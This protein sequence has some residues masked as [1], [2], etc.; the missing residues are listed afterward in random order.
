MKIWKIL[1]GYVN[2]TQNSR[3]PTGAFN[4]P[5]NIEK[6]NFIVVIQES[7]PD[8]DFSALAVEL[9][10][11]PER[12]GYDQKMEDLSPQARKLLNKIHSINRR[13]PILGLKIMTLLACDFG[14]TLYTDNF[15]ETI[16]PTLKTWLLS[17]ALP[18]QMRIEWGMFC[19]KNWPNLLANYSKNELIK[20][21]SQLLIEESRTNP[22]FILSIYD[23]IPERNWAG[24]GIFNEFHEDPEDILLFAR[25]VCHL[26][27]PILVHALI[28]LI[29]VRN[30]KKFDY[31]ISID[32]R[33]NACNE[34]YEISQK[35]VD[36]STEL[37]EEIL[38]RL[39]L[40]ARPDFAWYPQLHERLWNIERNKSEQDFWSIRNHMIVSINTRKEFSFLSEVQASYQQWLNIYKT[41]SWLSINSVV[42]HTK[43]MLELIDFAL[44]VEFPITR[45]CSR[46]EPM[47]RQLIEETVI[48]Y[49]EMIAYLNAADIELHCYA[50]ET[51]AER[52]TFTVK[53]TEEIGNQAQ[54]LLTN[55][56]RELCE[57]NGEK[58]A[59][60]ITYMIR[61]SAF[62][63]IKIQIGKMLDT[64]FPV[65]HSI[66]P[67]LANRAY[68]DGHKNYDG[69]S[70]RWYYEPSNVKSA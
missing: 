66:A 34:L 55:A 23:S 69:R 49:R 54:Q 20:P 36:I 22:E 39:I 44:N 27:P 41:K 6:E 13:N 3:P 57:L 15:G 5:S 12:R 63:G 48:A 1:T 10:A 25:N 45:N 53:L 33:K 26:R 51:A 68:I 21:L 9:S 62:T 11:L 52:D 4:I 14:H 30:G 35:N 31:P 65:L 29:D 40:R 70:E 2:R 18:R 47:N 58:A 24:K 16:Y 59:S 38:R 50:L 43:S 28:N 56:F 19:W 60:L 32:K 7:T 17:D 42:D 64:I 61:H 46:S 37:L 67:D 8:Y